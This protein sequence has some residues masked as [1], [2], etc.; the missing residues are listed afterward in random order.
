[1]NNKMS[2]FLDLKKKRPNKSKKFVII[3][4]FLLFFSGAIF[5]P[6]R[7]V[8]AQMPVTDIPKFVWDRI[9]EYTKELWQKGGSLAFQKTL[10][11]ALN[12]VAFDTANW[13]GSG[14]E[15]QKPL[16]VQQDW[17]AY[18][19]QM[20]DEAAGDFLENFTSNLAQGGSRDA[21]T[22]NV[23]QPSSLDVKVR[24]GLGLAQQYRPTAPRCRA[25]EM[26]RNWGDAYEKYRDFSDPQFLTKFVDIFD[27]ASSDLGI[28]WSGMNLIKEE[29]Q[30]AYEDARTKLL[31]KGGWL[32]PLTIDDKPISL[33]N[34]AELE[35]QT[36]FET[37]AANFGKYTGDAFIDSANLFL[38]QLAFSAFNN[39]M[40]N[41]GRKTRGVLTT[42]KSADDFQADPSYL[43]GEQVVRESTIKLTQAN[44]AI[45]ADYDILSELVI[46][47]DR[48]NPGPTNCVIDNKFMQAITEQKTVIEAI[49]EGYLNGNW[50]FTFDNNP[51]SYESSYNWR[52]IS[53]LRKH[54]ILPASWERAVEKIKLFHDLS[55]SRPDL[56]QAKNATLMDLVSCFDPLDE[57]GRFSSGF[58]AFDQAW[59]TGLVDPHWVL[60]APLNYCKKEGF[61]PQI[62]SK[63]IIPS[64]P[65][66]GT[67]P[68]TPSKISITRAGNYCADKQT[69]IKENDRGGCEIYG[70][71][72]EERR[73]WSFSGESCEPIDNTCQ[74]FVKASTGQRVA[75][76][77]NT[78][79]YENCSVDNAGCRAYATL[80]TYNQNTSQVDWSTAGIN[81]FNKRIETCTSSDEGCSEFI[82]V[83]PSWGANLVMNS[84][85]ANDTLG[86]SSTTNYL[87]DWP[88][89]STTASRRSTIVDSSVEPGQNSGPALKIEASGSGAISVSVFSD[90]NNSLVP[91][92]LAIL[93]GQAY[94]VSAD[95]YLA[96]GNRTAIALGSGATRK[97]FENTVLNAWQHISV[98]R[99]AD[100]TFLAPNFS[101]A[102]H[103]TNG[104]V[105]FY[106]KNIKLEM[107]SWDTGYSSY[108]ASKIYQKVLPN[109]LE[110]ACYVGNTV[111]GYSYELKP[112]APEV[113]FNYARQCNQSEVGCSL[114]KSNKNNFDVPAKVVSAD[115]CPGECV[116]YD[117]YVSRETHFNSSQAEN[118]IPQTASACSVEAVGCNEFTNLDDVG[119][120]G[121]QR[122]YYSALKHCAKPGQATCGNFYAW[123][124]TDNGYQLRLHPLQ[125]N[126]D[127]SPATIINDSALCNAEI[128]N[129]PV[130]SPLH[131][132]DCQEFYNAAG[133]SFYRL[134]SLTITCSDD[135]RSYR[136]T[137]K[138]YDY[139]I[140]SS[141]NCTGPA[142]H[143][144]AQ[145]GACVSCINGGTWS[146][147]H[148]ACVY[149]GIPGEGKVCNAEQNGC[150]EY[151]GNNG[152]NVRL[153]A[154]H[155]FEH[156]SPLW[157]SNCS[158]AISIEPISNNRDGQSLAY[159]SSASGCSA[160]GAE[161]TTLISRIDKKNPLIRQIMAGDNQAAQLKVGLSVSRDKAYIVRFWAR[162]NND[163]DVRISFYNRDSG[164]RA[165]FNDN[166]PV[167]ISGGGTWNLYSANLENL[168]HAVTENEMLIITADNNFYLDNFIL[169]EV[170]DRYYLIKNS[171]VIPNICYYDTEDVYRGVEYNLGCQAYVDH[172]GLNHNLH[173]FSKICAQDS[174][175]C[176]QMISTENYTPYGEGI[177]GDLNFNDTCEANEPDCFKVDS[178]R[179]MY[180]IYDPAK[181]CSQSNLGCSRLGESLAISNSPVWSD[182]FKKNNP[183]R[184]GQ[185]LCTQESLGCEEWQDADSG[186]FNYFRDPGNDVCVYRTSTLQPGGQKNWFKAPVKRCDLNT[187]NIIDRNEAILGACLANSNCATGNC[188]L[189]NNDYPCPVSYLE[190]I[191][192][193]G[194][195]KAI[196]VPSQSVGLCNI[197]ASGCTELIDPVS[198][199]NANL[200]SNSTSTSKITI[201]PN[202]LY[203]FS[204]TVKSGP[205][206]TINITFSS[207]S[208]PQVAP[209]LANNT[210]GAA[211]NQLQINNTVKS[212]IF[213]SLNSTEINYPPN[214]NGQFEIKEATIDYQ[215]ASELDKKSCNGITNFSNGCILFN[216]RSIV[217][218]SGYTNLSTG[219]DPFSSVNLSA[220]QNCNPAVAGSCAANVVIKARPDRTC[221]SWLDCRTYS[222]D[223]LTGEKICYSL[224]QC[225]SLNDFGECNNFLSDYYEPNLANA[226]GYYLLNKFNISNMTEVGLNSQAHF[227]FEELIPSLT[228]VTQQGSACLLGNMVRELIVREPE[229]AK[230]D[231]PVSG[232]S[233][234]KVPVAFNITPMAEGAWINLAPNQ[235]YYISYLL[236]T[237]NSGSQAQV[238]IIKN[239]AATGTSFFASSDDGWQRKTHVF[240]S[241]NGI[242]G[243]VQIRT[244]LRAKEPGASGEIYFDNINIEP[245]LRIG[246]GQYA[247]RDCRLFPT[248]DSL[249]CQNY[250]ARAIQNGL[251]G[252]CLEYDRFNPRVC[253]T[254]YPVDRISSSFLGTQNIGYMG[255]NNLSYCSNINV[256][257]DY[258][259]K[260][261]TKLVYFYVDKSGDGRDGALAINEDRCS[262]LDSGNPNDRKSCE[263]HCG[264]CDY[265]QAIFLN[266][267]SGYNREFV[268]C[269][270][271]QDSDKFRLSVGQLNSAK[272]LRP[273]P[274]PS[275]TCDNIKYFD[276][277]WM[278]Y[279]GNFAQIPVKECDEFDCE[280]IDEFNNANPPIRV[281]NRDFPP[282]EEGG[283]KLLSSTS[284]DQSQVFR[285]TCNNFLQTVS[286]TGDN[287]AWVLRTGSSADEDW[288]FSTPYFFNAALPPETII[289]NYGRQRLTM[290]F[291]A[292]TFPAD[293]DLLNSG[294]VY[295]RDQYF[296]KNIGAEA[297]FGGRPYGCSGTACNKVGY[298]SGNPNV[299]CAYDSQ[300]DR[301]RVNFINSRTCADGGFG[302]CRPLWQ[303]PSLEGAQFAPS[304]LS[305]IFR[306]TYGSFKLESGSYVPDSSGSFQITGV[307]N[308][309]TITNP[310]LTLNNANANFNVP[311]AGVYALKFNTYVDPEQQPLRMIFIDWGDGRTQA[312]TGQNYRPS[313]DNPHVF[314]HYYSGARN[315]MPIRIRVWDNW[316]NST[317]W[318]IN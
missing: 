115:Y 176:E 52:N 41:L 275:A 116:G 267:K 156:G 73:T 68:Y 255:P 203:I 173:S 139:S 18:M 240:N 152:N 78:L 55:I 217:G 297:I 161:N 89:Y 185:T 69:C 196:P 206:P 29:E 3:L 208:T 65:G 134:N 274:P 108:G 84:N 112:G 113:C 239:G 276:S 104:S 51:S 194:A 38:N 159:N 237:Q 251:E 212:I 317:E 248:N 244:L 83:K 272:M 117:I 306:Q 92:N 126:S 45:R 216:E 5:T 300:G 201:K 183:N 235:D 6:L 130:T 35:S 95:V 215:I 157:T 131:N 88:I 26:I 16:F 127:G 91:R 164:S 171:S 285:F 59:C 19:A 170:T 277:A 302:V 262:I 123:E 48:D 298:C 214:N 149:Q 12:K 304:V 10:R 132:P 120:G 254:W 288:N 79:N 247:S 49:E 223:E 174:V 175:G 74:A 180:L 213:N 2:P 289:N 316:D 141:A 39:L 177:W 22:F 143:W 66:Y 313:P 188:I 172:S 229:K 1:M 61:G 309:P 241:G 146:A 291:G 293:F 283:L 96:Q 166:K 122:E 163:T 140:T 305:Q 263:W 85:F 261:T 47:P 121:E 4:L 318:R 137:E 76:L 191:G 271:K 200:I 199:F 62:I 281:Y 106:V 145:E 107:S 97:T 284:G 186:G 204:S 153:V 243:V 278:E 11:T 36:A 37:Y 307:G 32:D 168:D 21:F 17:G 292:A 184:Y 221:A 151:N 60:K 15:G 100:N 144:D 111:S 80:G 210:F 129:A 205:A 87:N 58:D 46:C 296:N 27:P 71:C 103:S 303:L 50:L 268:F 135:C 294:P 101:I 81:Y 250:S 148:D 124:G 282:A 93:P 75:Y 209:L 63:Y 299:I 98:T 155:D 70:Y 13:I 256:N 252:Y 234:L 110:S 44:F 109:Y 233:Y 181:L 249:T 118:L 269:A 119:M 82:R 178:D 257:I 24:I 187:N 308:P 64:Q 245:V 57:Y 9:S 295:L 280:A 7:P 207:P 67:N 224:G 20:G 202:K 220:P 314:Y 179:A 312:F 43:R 287:K 182:V 290:P 226:T 266:Y 53:V 8:S 198:K 136:M 160:I 42:S 154:A 72:N 142:K 34:Q 246:R 28:Y 270:P 227:D 114:F 190:T 162:A 260:V 165:W 105:V 228:C 242:D 56:H 258:V 102:G 94:T 125:M 253:L 286:S 90:E 128:F 40:Q 14:G 222:Y 273:S 169:T 25:T 99:I 30:R 189:D 310:T 264:D 311:R 197:Q 193:G 158:N 230:V 279:D 259:K 133:Q 54:R 192:Y 195:G 238:V 219:F 23:C 265:Y 77:K 301:T 236:N 33:P 147:T 315:N 232:R 211:V 225:N 218:A 231:Y 167:R 150:R 31:G 86:A 138:N